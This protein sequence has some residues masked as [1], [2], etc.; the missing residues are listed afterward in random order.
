MTIQPDYSF[1]RVKI[2][3]SDNHVDSVSPDEFLAMK[4]NIRM[5]LLLEHR[6]EFLNG[7]KVIPHREALQSLRLRT[8]AKVA[9]QTHI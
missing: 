7:V 4:L 5:Q 2:R 8:V 1:D 3:Q 9:G 6:L